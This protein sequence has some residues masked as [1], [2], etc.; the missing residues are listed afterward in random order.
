MR[1]KSDFEGVEMIGVGRESR[2]KKKRKNPV[3]A[4]TL[5][6]CDG[7]IFSFNDGRDV[8]EDA[9]DV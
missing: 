2:R 5:N 7:V 3:F 6:R 9:A 4:H 8:R 1:L